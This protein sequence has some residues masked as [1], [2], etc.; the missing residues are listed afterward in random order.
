MRRVSS[1]MRGLFF[2][3]LCVKHRERDDKLWNIKLVLYHAA[4]I[5]SSIKNI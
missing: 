3:K 4:I 2:N 5:M 1:Q